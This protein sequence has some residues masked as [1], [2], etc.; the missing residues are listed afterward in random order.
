MTDPDYEKRIEEY[1]KN[2][3]KDLDPKWEIIN[4]EDINKTSKVVKVEKIDE[5]ESPRLKKGLS[6][7]FRRSSSSK[8][9]KSDTTSE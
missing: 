2:L 4:P 7:L 5:L 6:D 1:K 9:L 3:L 8:S